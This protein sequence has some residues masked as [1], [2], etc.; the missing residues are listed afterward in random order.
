MIKPLRTK[1]KK[2][3]KIKSMK[4]ISVDIEAGLDLTLGNGNTIR[5]IKRSTITETKVKRKTRNIKRIRR[6]KRKRRNINIHV[7]FNLLWK[8]KGVILGQK[9]VKKNAGTNK[10]HTKIRLR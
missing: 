5:K 9:K 2:I 8:N 7:K 10:F 6:R 4:I 3:K 1:M